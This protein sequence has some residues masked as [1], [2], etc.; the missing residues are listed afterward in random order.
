MSLL[1]KGSILLSAI[2]DAY[3]VTMTP[4]NFVINAS[5][6]GSTV[7]LND[8]FSDIRVFRGE[9]PEAFSIDIDSSSSIGIAYTVTS[10]DSLV[11]RIRITEIPNGEVNGWITFAITT[12][13]TGHVILATLNFTVVRETTMFDWILDWENNKT[14]I[15]DTYLITPKL[16]VGHRTQG[17]GLGTLSGVY[18]GPDDQTVGT[19]GIY[20]LHGGEEIFHINKDGGVIGGWTIGTEY[21]Y[22]AHVLLGA[23]T[24]YV[25]VS[26][27]ALTESIV[28]ASGFSHRDIVHNHGGVAMF[29]N[30]PQDY[31][32]EGYLPATMSGGTTTINKVFSLGNENK[33]AAW[34][35]DTDSLW[36]GTKSNVAGAGTSSSG[37]I[38]IGSNGLRGYGWYIDTGGNASFANGHVTLGYSTNLIAGWKITQ[39]RLSTSHVALVSDVNNGAVFVSASNIGN[40]ANANLASAI[41]GSGGIYMR[42]LSNGSELAGYS[43]GGNLLFYLSTTHP[44]QIAAWYFDNQALYIGTK[45]TSG[46]TSASGYITLSSTGIRG[47]KWR[48]ESTGV[49][50]FAGGFVQFNVDGGG[51]LANQNIIWDASGNIE[52]AGSSMELTG[53]IYVKNENGVI[54]AG[55]LAAGSGSAGIRFFAGDSTPA[56]APF[57]V[58]ETGLFYASNANVTGTISSTNGSIGGWTIDSDSIFKGTK[59]TSGFTGASGSITIGSTGIR[60]YKWRLEN[61]GE[62]VFADGKV[63]FHSNGSGNIANGAIYWTTN[64]GTFI[65][66][67]LLITDGNLLVRAGI[68]SVGS[69]SN[70]I[71]FFAGGPTLTT[72]PFR[73]DENGHVYASDIDADGGYIG[74][75]IIN[76]AENGGTIVSDNSGTPKVT[77][78]ASG[79]IRLYINS[80]E[81]CIEHMICGGEGYSRG[82]GSEIKLDA[83]LG[84]IKIRTV[85]DVSGGVGSVLLTPTGIYADRAGMLAPSSDD[86]YSQRAAIVGDGKS[87]LVAT[88]HNNGS[89]ENCVIGVYG[90]ATN[91]RESSA[92]PS[93]GGF[94]EGL[95]MR[96]LYL[97]RKVI[98][99]TGSHQ[100]DEKDTLVVA[101][102]QVN[103]TPANI[104]LPTEGAHEGRTIIVKLLNS[105][106]ATVYPGSGSYMNST[107]NTNGIMIANGETWVFILV[108]IPVTT[109]SGSSAGDSSGDERESGTGTEISGSTTTYYNVWTSMKASNQ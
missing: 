33:I 17:I 48:I 74:N 26:P 94:F 51:Y 3:S 83:D 18:I 84:I 78:D 2:D 7:D 97:G 44:S 67:S 100:L 29:Y 25:G 101:L 85:G 16:F 103:G 9:T 69:G 70:G 61:T 79:S 81:A 6:D 11:K 21:L 43:T 66:G 60:G 80:M 19:A 57:R 42:S 65:S 46:F 5:Y 22:S 38:T 82:I 39:G 36:I 90:S 68:S 23:D 56:R 10:V 47:F 108:K 8:A 99:A 64:G 58:D 105:G 55:M 102:P 53:A 106:E 63:V 93:Y 27:S 28:S 89:D 32:L 92:A 107:S 35:F 73:V 40:I 49:A 77:L 62:A 75:W 4:N 104:Y 96:G 50:V 59:A 91:T 109:S 1:A 30:T 86:T 76:S 20:G 24:S 37:S 52:F 41:E 95:K 45:A 31:G 98:T 88:S 71:R 13:L 72:A 15:G 54:K 14:T 12:V 87:T 34:N